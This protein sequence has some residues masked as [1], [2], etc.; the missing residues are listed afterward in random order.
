M[1]I[2]SWSTRLAAFSLFLQNA[3]PH[4]DKQL[5]D[6][7]CLFVTLHTVSM[8]ASQLPSVAIT[9]SKGNYLWQRSHRYQRLVK[10]SRVGP[11]LPENTFGFCKMYLHTEWESGS[12]CNWQDKRQ[13]WK[14]VV[15]T[16]ENRPGES[17]P[18]DQVT[19]ML[20]TKLRVS[21]RF[22]L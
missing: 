7:S 8:Y 14:H 20:K 6:R 13:I 2:I 9:I 17:W 22:S 18:R 12:V 4:C 16:G 5:H 21:V 1:C 11:L 19:Y 3:S 10:L 15:R